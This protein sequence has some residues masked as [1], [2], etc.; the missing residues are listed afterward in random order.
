MVLSF[1]ESLKSTRDDA[2]VEMEHDDPTCSTSRPEDGRWDGSSRNRA[3]S[4]TDASS[5]H[6]EAGM[7]G[8]ILVK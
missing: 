4:T 8:K 7:V 5:P 1:P 6:Y 2:N 3:S